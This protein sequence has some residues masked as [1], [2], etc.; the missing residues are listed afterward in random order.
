MNKILHIILISL[1]SLTIISCSSSSDG[2]SKSTDNTTT[3]NTTTDNTTTDNTTTTCD[4]TT[5]TTTSSDTTKPQIT[6]LS[7]SPSSIDTSSSSQPV[8]ATISIT[9]D[10]ALPDGSYLNVE[11]RL[12]SPSQNQFIDFTGYT[13]SEETGGT[14]VSR[15]FKSTST[16]T[17]GS[18]SGTWTI[19]YANVTD[20][21]GNSKSYTA[22]EL[23][24][25]GFSTT[26]SN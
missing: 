26:I 23:T 4:N 7:F 21:V 15:T 13:G 9:D 22:S 3:D 18:E 8:T 2:G 1:F 14:S 16:F 6:C 17:Q 25:L 20:K 5:T 19:Q 11:V 12:I 24:A 10:T